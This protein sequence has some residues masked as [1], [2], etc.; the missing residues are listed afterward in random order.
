[1][2]RIFWCLIFVLLFVSPTFAAGGEKNF[3]ATELKLMST[4][5]SNFTELGFM[6]FDAATFLKSDEIIRFGIR[7]NYINNYKSRIAK[8]KIR[9]C[10][11]GSLVIDAKHVTESIE[12]YFAVDFKDHKS[13]KPDYEFYKEYEYHYDGK[14]YHFEGADGEAVYY[15]RVDKAVRNSSGQIVMTGELY[16]ADDKDDKL[17]KF[18]AAAK[19]YKYGGKDTWAI[20]SMNMEHASVSDWSSIYEQL[21]NDKLRLLNDFKTEQGNVVEVGRFKGCLI[22]DIDMNGIPEFF[23]TYTD[24]TNYEAGEDETVVY[25]IVNGKL[26][27]A[28]H[29]YGVRFFAEKK[30]PGV[31]LGVWGEVYP[32]YRYIYKDGVFTD[33]PDDYVSYPDGLEGK[34]IK[35]GNSIYNFNQDDDSEQNLFGNGNEFVYITGYEH[36]DFQSALKSYARQ[37]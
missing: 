32:Q 22:Y 19:P 7:H 15:A 30:V 18:E 8:C 14:L 33:L 27:T 13:V 4:F 1:M 31:I 3:S 35:V 5:L 11:H 34:T 21:L 37:H 26:V 28:E 12:K 9:D 29:F 24:Y 17:G 6:N 10:P 23:V 25:S 2:K 16:N 36:K 20:I